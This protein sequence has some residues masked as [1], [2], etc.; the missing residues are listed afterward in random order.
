MSG[1]YMAR[2]ELNLPEQFYYTTSL[3]VRF[4]DLNVGF[5][6]GNDQMIAL[7]SEAR[8]RF[9]YHFE[10]EDWREHGMNLLVTDLVATYKQSAFGHDILQFDVGMMDFNKYG[11]DIIFRVTRPATGDLIVLAKTGFILIDSETQKPAL[12]PAKFREIFPDAF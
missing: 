8:S 2:V 9:L 4:T 3:T 6:V 12:L 7:L 1:V 11:G 10:I 5:H